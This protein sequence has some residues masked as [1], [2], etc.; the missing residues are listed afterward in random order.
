VGPIPADERL[1]QLR[2]GETVPPVSVKGDEC[3][4]RAVRW[5]REEAFREEVLAAFQHTRT[6]LLKRLESV[7]IA[8]RDPPFTIR[9]RSLTL[10][11]YLKGLVDHEEHHRKQNDAFL[12][13]CDGSWNGPATE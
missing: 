4:A 11:D 1:D 3:N 5:A 2:P 12:R 9:N 13:T 8:D 7:P 10:T 6:R